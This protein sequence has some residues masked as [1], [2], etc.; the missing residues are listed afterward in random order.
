MT[1]KRNK[2]RWGKSARKAQRAGVKRTLEEKLRSPAFDTIRSKPRRARI[3]PAMREILEEGPTKATA[4]R[5]AEALGGGVKVKGTSSPKMERAGKR[6]AF[7][8]AADQLSILAFRGV[9]DD[10]QREA[11][12]IFAVLR[13]VVFGAPHVRSAAFREMISETISAETEVGEILLDDERQDRDER[14]ARRYH[15]ANDALNDAGRARR[16][17]V[18][19]TAVYDERP[20]STD[21]LV[22]GL[23]VLA[24]VFKVPRGANRGD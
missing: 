14:C 24:N 22:A 7:E 21:D 8:D 1:T 11:G 10:R 23:D 20:K 6:V 19:C 17:A 3:T 16:E 13:M 15:A 9:I 12:R 18:W 5:K 2:R 4:Q